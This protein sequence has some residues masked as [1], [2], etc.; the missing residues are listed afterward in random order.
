MAASE[1]S[2]SAPIFRFSVFEVD[3]R[4]RE[5]RRSGARIRLQEQPFQILRFL[6]ERA[7]D[8][9]TRD[10]LRQRVWP[11]S[12][13]VDFDHGL[14]N[15]IA[16]L[17][18]ALHDDAATPR[19]IETLPK[20]GYRFICPVETMSA[21]SR[22][23]DNGTSPVSEAASTTPTAPTRGEPRWYRGRP[24][25]IFGIVALIMGLGL[26]TGVWLARRAADETRGA[27]PLREP[28]IVVLPFVNVDDP[29]D[30]EH[31]AES[32]SQEVLDKLV[33]IR[34]L[35][36]IG[37]TSSFGIKRQRGS[38]S[39]IANTLNVNYL[40]D[41]SVHRSGPRVHITAQLIDARSERQLWSQTYERDFIDV[42]QV[43]DEIALAVAAALQVKLVP[44]DELRFSNRG[45]HDAEAYR[46]Y[47]MGMTLL[48]G[49]GFNRDPA[50][51][52]QMFEEALARDPQFA[53]AH[54]GLALYYFREAWLNLVGVEDSVRLGHAALERA[55][56]LDPDSSEALLVKANFESWQSRFRGDFRAY[57]SA[58][59]D[60]R[61]AIELDPS[62]SVIFFNFAR[63][64]WWDEPDLSLNLFERTIELDPLWDQAL[65]F[66]ASMLSRR[67]LHEAALKRLH[68]LAAQSLSPSETSYDLHIGTLERQLG[69]LAEAE[70]YLPARGALGDLI[71]RWSLYLSLGD[72]AAARKSLEEF[73]GSELSEALREAMLFSMD[74]HYDKAFAALERH[75]DAFPLSRILDLPAARFA[76][77][78]G[79][80]DRARA[81]LEQRLPDLAHGVEPVKARNV[82]PALDLAAAYARTG[83]ATAANQLLGRIAAFL[84]GSD[85]P[86]WPMFIY[87]R[88]RTHALANEPELALRALDRAYQGGFRLI[89]GLDLHPQP[90]LYI[91]SIDSDPAFATLRADP[92]YKSWRER[93]NV[94][95]A[96]QLRNLRAHAAASPA[97]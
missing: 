93:I 80:A 63:A 56:A 25:L 38:P 97:A 8:V 52:A 43:Q 79:H 53:K 36:V 12:V 4:A 50:R 48:R 59:K 33:S 91:D 61:R 51:A 30:K 54:A 15:A 26:L 88:A 58:Q 5:L 18:E 76:L 49:R 82:I 27:P 29:A 65:G 96:R 47:M 66:S 13:Y 94:D 7:G 74:A 23:P 16:R 68:E 17:R 87:L 21:A 41:G 9:V 84:D 55:L 95:N 45:T 11:S 72:R 22:S 92:R 67:G 85:V 32:L 6:L 62:N 40:L 42:F 90:L 60:Y 83:D 37:P 2:E 75:C 3:C 24:A 64:I 10:E 1:P 46:L 77:I 28:S 86:R 39:V 81:F 34:A 70:S 69:H 14:N 31:F 35:K 71:Q 19:F 78:T 57:T 44:A 20:L 89:W 73:R